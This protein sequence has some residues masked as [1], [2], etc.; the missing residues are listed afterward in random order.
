MVPSEFNVAISLSILF[1]KSIKIVETKVV[2]IERKVANAEK[3]FSEIEARAA[4]A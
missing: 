1:L 3:D 2:V 4:E